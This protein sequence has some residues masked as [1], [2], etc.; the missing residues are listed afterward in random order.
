MRKISRKK[1]CE[2]C[3][4]IKALERRY[5]FPPLPTYEEK[6]EP[7]NRNLEEERRYDK[8][9]KILMVIS[10]IGLSVTIIGLIV[11]VVMALVK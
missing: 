2:Y 10:I 8:A 9:A 7:T 5:K 1:W 3:K 4:R 6:K 11:S